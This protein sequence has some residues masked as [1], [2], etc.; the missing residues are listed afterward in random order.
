[1]DEVT[2]TKWFRG[3]IQSR[4]PTAGVGALQLSG[5][6]AAVRL[7]NLKYLLPPKLRG[8][9]AETCEVDKNGAYAWS[10]DI[11]ACIDWIS[12]AESKA[13]QLA[14]EKEAVRAILYATLVK[15]CPLTKLTAV[16]CE[17]YQS[18]LLD[19]PKAFIQQPAKKDGSAPPAWR[20]FKKPMSSSASRY[21]LAVFRALMTRLVQTGYV[22]VSPLARV[23]L[24][25]TD[26]DAFADKIKARHINTELWDEMLHFMARIHPQTPSGVRALERARFILAFFY[27]TAARRNELA[28][29]EDAAVTFRSESEGWQIELTIKGGRKAVVPAHGDLIEAWRMYRKSLGKPP[30]PMRGGVPEKL[31]YSLSGKKAVAVDTVYRSFKALMGEIA[32]AMLAEAKLPNL[33]P[34]RKQ[35]LVD[36]ANKVKTI[37]PHWIRHRSITSFMASADNNVPLT[38]QFAR[39]RNIVTTQAYIGID[40]GAL[41]KG[42]RALPSIAKVKVP[43]E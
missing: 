6:S 3:A 26:K 13:T 2:P 8:S 17:Q 15:R 37:S 34:S 7:A 40:D 43:N 1:M 10:D 5:G 24:K 41:R 39:H 4:S 32:G 33:S 21:S 31:L 36:Y 20:P 16:D 9:P 19:P 23:K 27:Y 29:A 11:E 42:V 35:A 28:E 38:Q 22:E 25:T 18:F 12:R 30:V 14:Y